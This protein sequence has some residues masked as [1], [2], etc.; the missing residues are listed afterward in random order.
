M[1]AIHCCFLFLTL[2]LLDYTSGAQVVI[3]EYTCSNLNIHQDEYG[4]YEDWIELYN[5]GGSYVDLTGYYLTDNSSNL[6][7]YQIPA[8]Q[9]IA[10]GGF[11]LFYPDGRGVN[12]HCNFKLTQTKNSNETIVLSDP[13]LNL[14]VLIRGCVSELSLDKQFL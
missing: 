5:P 4:G 1:K 10:P 14:R 3:N 2:V 6:S 12:N 7:K 8:G 13:S 11:A 9:I